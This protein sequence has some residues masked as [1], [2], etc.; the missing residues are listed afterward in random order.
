MNN[1]ASTALTVIACVLVGAIPVVA[2][3]WLSQQQSLQAEKE[4]LIAYASDVLYRSERTAQQTFTGIDRLIRARAGDPCSDMQISLMAEIDVTSIDIQAMGYIANGD[5]L[6]SSFGRYGAGVALTGNP[7]VFGPD[8]TSV[9]TQV[10]LPFALGKT[11]IVIE[12][13]GYAAVLDAGTATDVQT[14]PSTISLATISPKNRQFRSVRGPVQQSW[15]DREGPD[16]PT[17]FIDGDYLVAVVKS[18]RFSTKTLA[19]MPVAELHARAGRAALYLL[20]FGIAAGVALALLAFMLARRQMAMPAILRKALRKRE[21]FLLYQPIVDLQS[22]KTIGAEALVRWRRS[23]GTMVPPDV[24]I[25]IAESS[26][27]IKQVTHQVLEMVTR[28]AQGLFQAHPDFHIGI[29]LSA[30]DLKSSK[31]PELLKQLIKDT[32]AGPRNLLVEATER[33]LMD[34]ERV[35]QVI[36]DIRAL[37]IEVAVDDFGTGYSSLSYLGTF[38]LDYL[39]IDK[40]FV[41][42][43]ETG[44]ATSDVALHIIEMAKALK[45]KM[46]AEGVETEPQAQLLAARGVQYAQGWLFARPM[47]MEAL[48]THLAAPAAAST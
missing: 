40:S 5:L 25:P 19:S 38:E 1:K 15:I 13:A 36:R 20:P 43:L 47:S 2:S 8:G 6:C 41:D 37:G 18:Q 46:I 16:T 39:K 27:L 48:K 7:P 10:E 44:A 42:T 31:T 23:D 4:R 21:L 28:D 11:F 33:G 35:R 29:N 14:D 30:A 45:L 9:R 3:F 26:G 34:A 32:A 22:R 12:R 17:T 24:F